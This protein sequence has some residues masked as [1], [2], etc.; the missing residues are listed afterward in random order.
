VGHH[1]SKYGIFFP[2]DEASPSTFYLISIFLIVE[3]I[4][5]IMEK[6]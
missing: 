2:S 3:M 5:E 1:G 6:N 4:E